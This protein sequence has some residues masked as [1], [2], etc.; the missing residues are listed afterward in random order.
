MLESHSSACDMVCSMAWGFRLIL[1]WP[2]V[3]LS[4]LVCALLASYQHLR[5]MDRGTKFKS[6]KKSRPRS[7][8]FEAVSAA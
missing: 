3:S 4:F 5:D 2:F 1:F 8:A 7:S 6:A